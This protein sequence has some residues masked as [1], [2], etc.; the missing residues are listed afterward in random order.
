[1]NEIKINENI[2]EKAIKHINTLQK[3]IDSKTVLRQPFHIVNKNLINCY[4]KILTIDN[5]MTLEKEKEFNNFIIEE[6]QHI[7]KLKE[8]I[9][10]KDYEYF[11]SLLIIANEKNVFSTKDIFVYLLNNNCYFMK[12]INKYTLIKNMI[13]RYENIKDDDYFIKFYEEI[14]LNNKNKIKLLT[15]KKKKY[16]K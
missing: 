4:N 8:K 13:D 9:S 10:N 16:N 7:N 1:M 3:V 14:Q 11:I 2:H 6:F 15:N 12:S 5:F